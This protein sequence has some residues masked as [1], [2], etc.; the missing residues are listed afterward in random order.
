[1]SAERWI[2]KYYE[3]SGR[4]LIDVICLYL[5]GVTEVNYTELQLRQPLWGSRED[6]SSFS[7]GLKNPRPGLSR[8]V[9]KNRKKRTSALSCLS[10]RPSAHPHLPT[11]IPLDRFFWN[12]LSEVFVKICR[13]NSKLFK[14]R[15]KYWAHYVRISAH[16]MLLKVTSVCQ[17]LYKKYLIVSSPW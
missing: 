12:F 1:M 4:D 6:T 17:Q 11:A 16:F 13:E 3:V 5:P 9:R 14:I 10:V 7:C 8:G 2:W 15:Q